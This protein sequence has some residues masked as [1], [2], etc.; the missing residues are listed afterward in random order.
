MILPERMVSALGGCERGRRG[1]EGRGRAEKKSVWA[2]GE[3]RMI[4]IRVHSQREVVHHCVYLTTPLRG[5]L[6]GWVALR[7][8]TKVAPVASS[9]LLVLYW[10]RSRSATTGGILASLCMCVCV[11]ACVCVHTYTQ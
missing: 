8:M 7:Y 1:E 9:T 5:G 10:T 3:G 2:R 6:E 11:R 4:M